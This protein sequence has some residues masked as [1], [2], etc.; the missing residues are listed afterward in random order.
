[1]KH[2]LHKFLQRFDKILFR[3]E[4]LG[5]KAIHTVKPFL[6]PRSHNKIQLNHLPWYLLLGAESAGKSTLLANANI[7]F[8][9]K[10]LFQP[11]EMQALETSDECMLYATNDAALLDVPGSYFTETGE[12]TLWQNFLALIKKFRRNHLAGVVIALSLSDLTD[13]ETQEIFVSTLSERIKDLKETFGKN[14]PFYFALTKCDLI[15]GFVDFFS[16]SGIDELAQAWGITIPFLGESESVT[17]VFTHRFN[18]LIKRL[19]KQLIWRLHQERGT[20]ARLYV[21]DFPLQIERL[22]ENLILLLRTLTETQSFNLQG[23]YLTSA[24]QPKP[25]DHAMHQ[26]LTTNASQHALQ[27]MYNPLMPSRSYFIRQFLLQTILHPAAKITRWWQQPSLVYT[28]CACAISF[29]VACVGQSIFHAR[30]PVYAVQTPINN[31]KI[32][33]P[34]VTPNIGRT[35]DKSN[36]EQPG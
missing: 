11:E 9:L 6:L 22:K 4:S 20:T 3:L 21:K 28:V 33:L 36:A 10:K 16:E 17:D 31:I 18:A 7:K 27:I 35:L 23:V 13:R 26:Q 25:E 5:L 32:D 8:A 1:M 29:T 15:P 30:H 19:N 34:S 2:I 14:V 24:S 12:D